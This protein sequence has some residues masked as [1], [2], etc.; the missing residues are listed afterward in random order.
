MKLK[1]VDIPILIIFE[2]RVNRL[3][4]IN[5][6]EVLKRG[7]LLYLKISDKHSLEIEK[8]SKL[9][10]LIGNGQTNHKYF[11]LNNEHYITTEC[12]KVGEKLI[13]DWGVGLFTITKIFYKNG[14]CI[15]LGQEE[16]KEELKNNLKCK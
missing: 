8:E 16:I 4:M 13:V 14:E 3:N 2:T 11:I 12:L 6:T 5:K 9:N 7:E 15:E 1:K 10:D